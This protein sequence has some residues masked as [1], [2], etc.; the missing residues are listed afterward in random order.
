M[1]ANLLL[2]AVV[3]VA[4]LASCYRFSF[5][6]MASLD[7]ASSDE[8]STTMLNLLRHLPI[9]FSLQNYEIPLRCIYYFFHVDVFA[10]L[11][12]LLSVRSVSSF[13]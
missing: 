8:R 13:S 6:L 10:V 12:I 5:P 11:D 1:P 2:H 4:V 3:R 9:E 7:A